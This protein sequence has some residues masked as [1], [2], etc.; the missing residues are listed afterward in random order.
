MSKKVF[1]STIP[2]SVESDQPRIM[3]EDAGIEYVINPLGRKL[4]DG[5][6]AN[7]VSDIDAIIAGTE[8][9]SEEVMQHAP[10][11]KLISRVGI[12][13]DG[14]DLNAARSQGIEVAYTPDAPSP[15]VAELAIG[16]MIAGLRKVCLADSEI[17]AGMW[18]RYLGRR[19]GGSVVGIIG[20]GRIGS[21]VLDH[22]RPFGCKKILVNDIRQNV[23][24]DALFEMCSKERIFSESDVITIHVPLTTE[25]RNMITSREMQLMKKSV[26]LVNTSRGGIIN[27]ADLEHALT[28]G[29][30]SGAAID[31][32][33]EEPYSGSLG[34]F[35]HCILTAH[36]GSMSQDCRTKMEVE[37]TKAVA[38][39]LKGKVMANPVPE[40]EYQIQQAA[41]G[42]D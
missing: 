5:E 33:S 37:A 24:S 17:R 28:L 15:A 16:L 13:L 8:V 38:D 32:F 23:S 27:E 6:L 29:W 3:L 2:F 4:R 40:D 30:I 7:F 1:I 39:F 11:L 18:N 21:R 12:G 34:K 25:T 20:A 10:K 41:K 22:L 35:P 42:G 14:V 31:V 9:I 26:F 36:M 19:L